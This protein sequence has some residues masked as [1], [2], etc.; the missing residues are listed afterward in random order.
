MTK[1]HRTAIIVFILTMAAIIF[2]TFFRNG[3][4]W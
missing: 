2:V 3:T 4:A 1:Q